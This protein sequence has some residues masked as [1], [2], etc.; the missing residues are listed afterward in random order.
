MNHVGCVCVQ[1]TGSNREQV[2]VAAFAFGSKLP[3]PSSVNSAIVHDENFPPQS[4]CSPPTLHVARFN[5]SFPFRNSLVVDDRVSPSWFPF[6]PKCL[7]NVNK[8]SVP[9]IIIDPALVVHDCGLRFRESLEIVRRNSSRETVSTQHKHRQ[10]DFDHLP[11]KSKH[12][13]T[14]TDFASLHRTV[15]TSPAT[16]QHFLIAAL[17]ESI[18]N[19]IATKPQPIKSRISKSFD[20][21]ELEKVF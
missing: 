2:T 20:G 10:L 11:T 6:A 21:T 17:I 15:V 4:P 9:L 16:R 12:K 5:D 3:G 18:G 1:I 8:F 19:L 14:R 13:R 7:P